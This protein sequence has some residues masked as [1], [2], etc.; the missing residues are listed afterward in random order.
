[1]RKL[2]LSV[3]ALLFFCLSEHSAAQLNIH[4]IID[5]SFAHGG[6]VELSLS[7]FGDEI[8]DSYGNFPDQQ[9]VSKI[10]ICGKIGTADPKL[11]KFGII[12]LKPNGT[13]DSSFA[14]NG[15]AIL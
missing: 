4:A 15:K 9:L 5:T 11:K 12:R 13:F 8:T 1:M 3:I 7:G 10:T 6:K 2:A 14:D